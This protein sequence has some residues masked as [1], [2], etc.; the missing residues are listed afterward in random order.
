[1]SEEGGPLWE[2]AMLVQLSISVMVSIQ[3]CDEAVTTKF[4]GGV[5][6]FEKL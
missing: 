4:D 5:T 1:M 2:Q 6:W 3:F